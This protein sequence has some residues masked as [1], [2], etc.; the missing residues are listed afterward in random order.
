MEATISVTRK[1]Q[2]HIPKALRGA[3]GPT[4]PGQV[5]IRAEKGKL[6]ISSSQSKI[7]SLA[8]KFHKYYLKNKKIDIDNIRD[9][10]DYSKA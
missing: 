9:Y 4:R 8:G 6:I 5:K 10:I 7:L 2:I 3:L 1:W